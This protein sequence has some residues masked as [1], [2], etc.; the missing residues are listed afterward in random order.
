MDIVIDETGKTLADT[1]KAALAELFVQVL[2]D[3]SPERLSREDFLT[4]YTFGGLSQEE[5]RNYYVYTNLHLPG[6]VRRKE[7]QAP[8]MWFVQIFFRGG[9]PNDQFLLP[10][11]D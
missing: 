5:Q 10:R 6:P 2:N 4:R 9:E 11:L 3:A 1:E 7:P 8:S